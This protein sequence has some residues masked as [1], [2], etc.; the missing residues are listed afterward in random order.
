MRILLATDGSGH[1]EAAVE[2]IAHWHYPAGSE[3]RIISVVELRYFPTTYPLGGVDLNLYDQMEKDARE[4]T[5]KAADK[6]RAGENNHQLSVATKVLYGSPK[7]VILEEAEAFGAN[8]IVVGS[9]SWNSRTFPARLSLTGRRTTRQ[10]FGRACAPPEN[11][12]ERKK[13]P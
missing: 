2:E 1:S 13:E 4:V 6:L 3:V 10:M 7:E 9:R 5:E 12:D 8:L 11:A